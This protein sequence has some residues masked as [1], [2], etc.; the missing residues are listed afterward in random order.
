MVSSEQPFPSSSPP[1]SQAIAESNDGVA[2]VVASSSK[3][4]IKEVEEAEL[5]TGQQKKLRAQKVKGKGPQE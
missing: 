2:E 5:G 1:L 3:R 4:P